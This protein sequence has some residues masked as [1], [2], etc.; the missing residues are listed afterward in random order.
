MVNGAHPPTTVGY[1]YSDEDEA[2][3]GQQFD[4]GENAQ[5]R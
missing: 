2:Q 1:E 4:L 3:D 5:I